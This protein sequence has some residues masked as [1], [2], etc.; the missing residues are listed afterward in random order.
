MSEISLLLD[1]IRSLK[2]RLQALETIAEHPGYAASDVVLVAGTPTPGN[3]AQWDD[4][5]TV[6]DAGVAVSGLATSGHTHEVD[7]RSDMFSDAEGDPANVATAAADGASTYAARR[8]H[9][10]ALDD[11]VVTLAKMAN[12]AQDQ[13]IG[14]TTASTGVPQTATITAAARTV[15]DDATVA[16]MATTLGL[17]TGDSPQFTGVNLGHASDTLLARVSAGL[18]SIAGNVLAML[19]TANAFTKGQ[20][21]TPD[22]AAGN[23]LKL[24]TAASPT[25]WIAALYRNG[26]YK[27]SWRLGNNNYVEERRNFVA[28]AN[29]G[30]IDLPYAIDMLEVIDASGVNYAE[31]FCQ[32]AVNATV[33]ILDTGG[34]FTTTKDTA[35]S[36]NVYYES[37]AYHLQNKRGVS[38]NVALRIVRGASVA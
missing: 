20:T 14:R 38:R 25:S 13:F 1:E 19:G 32:G 29:D 11:A 36:F 30:V 4:T 12:L 31:Y 17:G 2:R 21:I 10:H 5:R 33:E 6:E 24:D 8:N 28:L 18:V 23:S 16:A 27:M 22:T 26:T 37:S 7:Q 34:I 3:L 35:S 15:L 9:V